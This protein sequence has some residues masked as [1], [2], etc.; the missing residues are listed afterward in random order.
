MRHDFWA[1]NVSKMF[2]RP[3]L[4]PVLRWGR[5]QRFA[6]FIVGFGS[7][8][9]ARRGGERERRERGRDGGEGKGEEKRRWGKG[10]RRGGWDSAPRM[11]NSPGQRHNRSKLTRDLRRIFVKYVDDFVVSAHCTC[12]LAVVCEMS[13][14]V[15]AVCGTIYLH[16]GLLHLADLS[17]TVLQTHLTL[18]HYK[19]KC[20]KCIKTD[21]YPVGRQFVVDCKK[22]SNKS[23]V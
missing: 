17:A 20:W 1:Q 18:R 23:C 4:R 8:L 2:L 13:A 12:S 21:F 16:L 9:A 19:C 11:I 15:C 22:V 6:S 3:G 7:H 14:V 5:S 10:G